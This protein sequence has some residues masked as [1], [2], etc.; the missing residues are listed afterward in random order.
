MDVRLLYF[1][2]C[3]NHAKTLSVLR[4]LLAEAGA[5]NGVELVNVASLEDAKRFEF[6]GSPTVLLD[7]VDPFLDRSA[8]IGLACRIYRSDSGFQG[9]PPVEDLRRAIGQHLS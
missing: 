1:D 6:R 3:P 9:T 4:Q 8:P 5:E 2:G 7:G